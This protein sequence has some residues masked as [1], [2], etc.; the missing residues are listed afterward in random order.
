MH[1][2]PGA[3]EAEVAL[4]LIPTESLPLVAQDALE[5]GFSGPHVVR[6]AVLDRK[7]GWA[8]DQELPL[9]LGDLGCREIPPREAALR[10]ARRRAHRVLETGEDSLAAISYF[11]QLMIAADYP[12]ELIELAYFEDDALFFSSHPDRTERQDR[13]KQALE[14]LLRL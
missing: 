9:M 3:F 2:D 6:M 10:L 1:F 14:N 13:V 11:H 7:D 12:R 5:A 8:I 4:K